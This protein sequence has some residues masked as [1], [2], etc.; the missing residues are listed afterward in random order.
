M[1]IIKNILAV[2]FAAAMVF[3]VSAD[4]SAQSSKFSQGRC[5]LYTETPDSTGAVTSRTF[6]LRYDGAIY[7]PVTKSKQGEWRLSGNDFSLELNGEKIN[8]TSTGDPMHLKGT[9]TTPQGESTG[10]EV[11]FAPANGMN[12]AKIKENLLAGQYKKAY[13]HFWKSGDER[14]MPQKAYPV[15]AKFNPVEGFNGGSIAISGSPELMSLLSGPTI[16]YYFEGN[17]LKTVNSNGQI[18]ED[19]LDKTDY[20]VWVRFDKT[21]D[22]P[23]VGEGFA[24]LAIYF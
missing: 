5:M 3:G 10:C 11:C 7:N 2:C 4:L 22:I 24:C 19:S 15:E 9:Y 6:D 20:Y 18:R 16:P 14:Y 17:V 13:V 1:K 8:A 12:G 23:G 21:V